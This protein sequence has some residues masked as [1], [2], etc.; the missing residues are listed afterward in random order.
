MGYAGDWTVQLT[1]KPC[2]SMCVMPEGTLVEI[3]KE[4]IVREHQVYQI[5]FEKV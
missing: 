5:S 3:Q 4:R 2:E 1:S